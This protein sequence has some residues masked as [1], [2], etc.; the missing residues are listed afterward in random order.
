[1]VRPD[2][3]RDGR[4]MRQ[5][6]PNRVR[7]G[8]QFS[9]RAQSYDTGTAGASITPLIMIEAVFAASCIELVFK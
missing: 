6:G 7:P 3:G 1:M 5:S 9:A 8:T 4:S 2:A